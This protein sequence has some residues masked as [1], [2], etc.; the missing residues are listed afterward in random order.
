MPLRPPQILRIINMNLLNKLFPNTDQESTV[1]EVDTSELNT[2]QVEAE[3]KL[4]GQFETASVPEQNA[5]PL[6]TEGINCIN[7]FLQCCLTHVYFS[8]F[9]RG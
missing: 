1:H 8:N 6:F 4:F 7:T 3:T 9:S 5:L 2:I